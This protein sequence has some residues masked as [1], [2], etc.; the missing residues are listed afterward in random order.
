MMRG[1]PTSQMAFYRIEI[2]LALVQDRMLFCN[3][4]QGSLATAYVHFLNLAWKIPQT[5]RVYLPHQNELVGT[6]LLLSSR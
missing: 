3:S 1:L 2:N 6:H 4:Q 5:L